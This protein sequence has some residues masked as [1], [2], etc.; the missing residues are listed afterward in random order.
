MELEYGKNTLCLQSESIKNYKNL[1]I[2]DDLLATGGTASSVEKM[3]IN[4]GKVVKE[5]VVVVELEELQ[6]RAN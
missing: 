6:G 2:V 3:L 4:Q 1:P 5:L